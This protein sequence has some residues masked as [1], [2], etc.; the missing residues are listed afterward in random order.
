MSG[1]RE[2]IDAFRERHSTQV[3]AGEIGGAG[4]G[5]QRVVRSG[6]STLGLKRVRIRRVYRSPGHYPG[7]KAG[8]RGPRRDAKV[9]A[10]GGWAGVGH[11]L[12]TENR[13]AGRGTQSGRGLRASIRGGAHREEKHG[14]GNDAEPHD[15]TIRD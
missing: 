14:E 12:A 10:D 8:D 11:R 4:L 15:K 6:D 2:T 3:L 5:C 1:R 13:I 7:R 9:P